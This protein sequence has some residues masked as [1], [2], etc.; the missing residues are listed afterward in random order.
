[1]TLI[2]VMVRGR[3][4]HGSAA[5]EG[6]NSIEKAMKIVSKMNRQLPRLHDAKAHPLLGPPT[7]NIGVIRAGTQP[8]IVPDQCVML[9]DR[10]TLPGETPDDLKAECDKVIAATK[11]ED[12][13][14]DADVNVDGIVLS[15]MDTPSDAPFVKCL[16]EVVDEVCGK[17][18]F[19]GLCGSTDGALL[20][21]GGVPSVVF[22]QATWRRPTRLT[23]HSH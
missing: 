22:V 1:M 9:I 7:F 2:R 20:S 21:A 10:R 15:V 4:A 18:E 14:V 19:V 8:I 13:K 12:S 3:T 6:V 17:P 23:S 16:G 11:I 5:H